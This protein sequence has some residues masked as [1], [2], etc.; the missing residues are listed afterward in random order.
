MEDM[1]RAYLISTSSSTDATAASAGWKR[2]CMEFRI[3]SQQGQYRN[4][5]KEVGG[6][7]EQCKRQRMLSFKEY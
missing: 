4:A 6:S 1:S 3:I 5:A 7:K 2:I